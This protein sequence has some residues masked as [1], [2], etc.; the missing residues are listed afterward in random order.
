MKRPDYPGYP[1]SKKERN[2]FSSETAETLIRAR[3]KS[4]LPKKPGLIPDRFV[5]GPFCWRWWGLRD[6]SG[7]FATHF[8][9]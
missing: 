2:H 7:N 6:D 3:L 1:G 5:A 4:E 9:P 8:T